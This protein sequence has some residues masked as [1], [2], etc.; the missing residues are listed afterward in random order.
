MGFG[1]ALSGLNAAASNLDIIGNNI[2]NAGTVGFKSSTA[3]FADVYANA[4]VGLGTQLIGVKQS[5][6]TGT[7][8]NTGNAFDI[9]VDGPKGFFRVLDANGVIMYTRNGQF[10]PDKDNFLVNAQGHQLTGYDVETGTR[11]QPIQIPTGNIPPQQTSDVDVRMNVDAGATEPTLPFDPDNPDSYNHSLPIN[12]FDK[13]GTMHQMVQ[14]FRKTATAN[15]WNVYYVVNGADVTVN[16][17]GPSDP[18]TNPGTVTF[19]AD[20]TLATTVTPLTVEF[21]TTDTTLS[22]HG[23]QFTAD[24]AGS[25]QYQGDFNYSFK[26]DGYPTGEYAS[27]SIEPDGSIIANYTNG[28]SKEIGALVLAD[29]VS[30]NGLK[31]A[32]G[33]AWVET[34]ASGQPI[35]GRPGSNSLATVISMAVEESNVD[36]SQELVNLI[37]AQRT[38]QANSQTIKT[39]DQILQSLMS[40]R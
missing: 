24:Y 5:F 3:Q 25:T 31:A 22:L 38:Y 9:A 36:L 23:T 16:G 26:Q 12:I 1:Q 2:A 37:I 34:G 8:S 15:E 27:T 4:S 13:Q 17:V 28:E 7:I 35:L 40:L 21:T 30:V 10:G 39:Q 19:N 6:D 14:Y 11:L 29:F 20:G 18:A 33:N 32:G